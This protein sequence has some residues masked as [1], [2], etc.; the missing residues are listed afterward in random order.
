[1]CRAA[2]VCAHGYSSLVEGAFGHDY[3][4]IFDVCIYPTKS[5]VVVDGSCLASW[6]YFKGFRMGCCVTQEQR[7]E[8]A[9]CLAPAEKLTSHALGI[10]SLR[11]TPAAP[12]IL[13]RSFKGVFYDC[14]L[15]I[16]RLALSNPTSS[17]ASPSS[18]FFC[19]F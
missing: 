4:V 15:Y 17:V 18:F 1:M 8:G 14:G 7:I 6:M 13:K 11:K 10:F 19:L 3:C 16:F 9:S 12:C 5:I 2:F